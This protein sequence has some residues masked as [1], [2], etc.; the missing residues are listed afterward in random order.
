VVVPERLVPYRTVRDT[1]NNYLCRMQYQ[2]AR[3][4]ISQTKGLVLDIA[5]GY[6]YGPAIVNAADCYIRSDIDNDAIK[7]ASEHCGDY[8]EFHKYDGKKIPYDNSSFDIVCSIETIEHIDRQ[9]H[10]TF[11]N[12]LCRALK[13]GGTLIIST[14]NRDYLWKKMKKM[15]GWQNPYHKYEFNKCEFIKFLEKKAVISEVLYFG[16][17]LKLLTGRLLRAILPKKFNGKLPLIE[18]RSGHIHYIYKR[19]SHGNAQRCR[20]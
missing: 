18:L 2:E 9:E 11:Y 12:E 3:K 10:E 17:P 20:I 6:G 1:Y 8:G 5:C 4:Y 13:P 16:F 15:L 7:Y 14:P 19:N